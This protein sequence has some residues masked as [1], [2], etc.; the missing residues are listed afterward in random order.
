MVTAH[1]SCL[2]PFR[3]PTT[4][5]HAHRLRRVA[6]HE[7][8]STSQL[9]RDRERNRADHPAKSDAYSRRRPRRCAPRPAV[10]GTGVAVQHGTAR[11]SRHATSSR[12]TVT[13]DPHHPPT[14][15]STRI[16][17][18]STSPDASPQVMV[19][20]SWPPEVTE[21]EPSLSPGTRTSKG[22]GNTCRS[23]EIELQICTNKYRSIELVE[24]NLKISS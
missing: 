2:Y 23:G 6:R 21:K 9:S 17:V 22:D 24:I 16:V 15:F 20:P 18:A 19:L 4:A 13:T 11:A 10:A 3:R 5:P 1:S 12:R 14:R 7:S 8:I